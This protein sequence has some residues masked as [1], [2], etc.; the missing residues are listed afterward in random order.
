[1]KNILC[2][3][4]VLIPSLLMATRA[5]EVNQKEYQ[6]LDQLALKL[7]L[8]FDGNMT[9]GKHSKWHNYSEPY[10]YYFAAIKDKPIKFLEI[11]MHRGVSVQLWENYFKN[12]ELHFV[13]I[14][15]N[16]VQYFSKRSRYHLA[17][18]ADPNQLI[19]V[20]K[21]TGGEFDII[22]EDGGHTM[23]Q[24]ITSFVT[25]FPYLK[26]G[27]LYI[28]EDL[29][30]SYWKDFGGHGTVESPQAGPNTAIQFLKDLIDDVNF[31]GARTA[32]ATRVNRD[33]S[34]IQNEM[35]I[36]R[37]E[38]FAMHFYDSLCVIIKR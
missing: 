3:L 33:L 13:D 18:Q 15:F 31:V 11:G 26:S 5:F 38:I 12:A 2:A 36:Y 9:S 14:N 19:Q 4:L 30:T 23:V 17:D 10:A 28:I 34:S 25:L 27:G 20:M 21:E 24:Q 1:M 7:D 37:K 8:A 22:I 32:G 6:E 35:N 29:H 16:L